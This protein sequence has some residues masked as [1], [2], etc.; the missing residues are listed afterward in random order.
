MS[1]LSQFFERKGIDPADL[2]AEE[3]ATLE[4]WKNTFT[5]ADKDVTVAD[6]LAFCDMNIKQIEVEFRSFDTPPEKRERQVIAYSTYVAIRNLINAP[7]EQR[8]QFEK[9]LSTLL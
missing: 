3:K 7:R 4:Q 8:E 5:Q 2:N 6:I 9:Y 1:V